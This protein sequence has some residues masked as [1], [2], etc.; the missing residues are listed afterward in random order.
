MTEVMLRHRLT[1]WGLIETEVAVTPFKTQD[2]LAVTSK[3]KM[4]QMTGLFQSAI[5]SFP[6]P[7][8]SQGD[9]IHLEAVNL[10]PVP[11]EG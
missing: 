4:G 6:G 11:N 9:S 3:P 8:G 7:S 10:N 5:E 2:E 1:G